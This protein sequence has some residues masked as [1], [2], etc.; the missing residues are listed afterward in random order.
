MK[1]ELL[2]ENK[3]AKRHDFK[4]YYILSELEQFLGRKANIRDIS[5]VWVKNN[6]CLYDDEF[7]GYFEIEDVEK[8]KEYDRDKFSRNSSD[9]NKQIYDWLKQTGWK[10]TNPG[11]IV[12]Y[13]DGR[14]KLSEGN[15]RL[16]IALKLGIKS[17]PILFHFFSG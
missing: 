8:Y 14:I 4:S 13:K 12:V 7:H 2:L 1:V 17:I 16:A 6:L 9:E 3:F 5:N 11:Q 15:H 10:Q